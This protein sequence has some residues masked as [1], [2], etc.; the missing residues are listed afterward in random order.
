MFTHHNILVGPTSVR[1][2]VRPWALHPSC[3]LLALQTR[4]GCSTFLCLRF[5]IREA[6]LIVLSSYNDSGVKRNNVHKGLELS[7]V[8]RP[9]GYVSYFCY[10][11]HWLIHSFIP[12]WA[13][14]CYRNFDLYPFRIHSNFMKE[15]ISNL[16]LGWGGRR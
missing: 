1:I 2:A 6:G 8:H 3:H 5:L 13:G 7:R 11:Y 10:Y 4:T 12:H 9:P 14:S 15:I 16:F